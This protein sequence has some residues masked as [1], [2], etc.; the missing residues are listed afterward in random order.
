MNDNDVDTSIVVKI[1]SR[2]SATDKRPREVGRD[3]TACNLEPPL[4]AADKKLSSLAPS[5]Y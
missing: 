4:S 1:A 5:V 2:D 3:V